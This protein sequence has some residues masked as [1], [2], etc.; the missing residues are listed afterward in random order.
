MAKH[1]QLGTTGEDAAVAYLEDNG[2]QIR[3]RN[4]HDGRL[5]IDIV[6]A[7]SGELYIIEVK[8]RTNTE[9]QEPQDAV[10]TRKRSHILRAADLY[11]KTF[12]ITCVVH[13]DIVTV[14]GEV[15]NFTIEHIK[16]AFY[17][18]FH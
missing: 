15:G 8:T 10:D 1:N 17:P 11:L 3:H 7:K 18:Y 5:E 16:D 6:A 9:Y 13:F 4:W 14:V 12:D 2:Y